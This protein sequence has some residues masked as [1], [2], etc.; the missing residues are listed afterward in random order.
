MRV[1]IVRVFLAARF[2]SFRLRCA[3]AVRCESADNYGCSQPSGAPFP[4]HTPRSNG[5]L[6]GGKG[7]LVSPLEPPGAAT[8]TSAK[9]RSDAKR[10]P[11]PNS[12]SRD[13]SVP[14][15]KLFKYRHK[16]KGARPCYS[17][18]CRRLVARASTAERQRQF[19]EHRLAPV[20]GSGLQ[21]RRGCPDRRPDP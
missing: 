17:A 20:R 15:P 11:G 12:S 5:V 14:Q 1:T 3:N 2:P 7:R 6:A 4:P 16:R 13:E 18:L 10:S 9:S 8:H 21:R 19:A